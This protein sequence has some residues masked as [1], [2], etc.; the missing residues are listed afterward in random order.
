MDKHLNEKEI[1]VYGW[2]EGQRQGAFHP[3]KQQEVN[4]HKA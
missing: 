2:M 3:D 1:Y 4:T